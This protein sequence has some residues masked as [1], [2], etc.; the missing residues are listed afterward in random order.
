MAD[1][2]AEENEPMVDEDMPNGHAANS[3]DS[4]P[5]IKS[6]FHLHEVISR[7]VQWEILEVVDRECFANLETVYS[8]I[9]QLYAAKAK[10]AKSSKGKEDLAREK[11]VQLRS[12]RDRGK[13]LKRQLDSEDGFPSAKRRKLTNGHANGTSSS[14]TKRRRVLNVRE[15][16]PTNIPFS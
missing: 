5:V 16:A 8:E 2:P 10:E 12:A 1:T 7:L 13:Q 4:G 15:K 11:A 14:P 9:E 6:V 3:A